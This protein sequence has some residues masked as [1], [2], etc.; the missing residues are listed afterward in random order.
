[1]H[2]GVQEPASDATELPFVINI[3]E[4]RDVVSTADEPWGGGQ[5][6][7]TGFKGALCHC[8]N[9]PL[10]VKRGEDAPWGAALVQPNTD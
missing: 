3:K 2:L 6:N 8:I 1:M 7:G 10:S 9:A 5:R 4:S